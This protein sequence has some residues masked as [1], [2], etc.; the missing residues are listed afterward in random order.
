MVLQNDNF[1]PQTGDI[2]ENGNLHLT[3]GLKLTLKS[4]EMMPIQTA[5][6]WIIPS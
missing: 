1:I 3:T 5:N 4:H 2:T 6:K